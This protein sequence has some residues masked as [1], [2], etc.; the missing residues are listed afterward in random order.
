[1]ELAGKLVKPVHERLQE[2]LRCGDRVLLASSSLD[3]IIAPVARCLGVEWVASQLEF[4]NDICTGRLATD[5]TGRKPPALAALLTPGVS[6]HVY[7]DN[8]SDRDL[9]NLADQRTVI[10]PRSSKRGRWAGED[11][12]YL[13]V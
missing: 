3:L 10:V 6:L 7:T 2:H 5:L 13:P 1:V 8:R 9:L 11:C 4:A 12:E